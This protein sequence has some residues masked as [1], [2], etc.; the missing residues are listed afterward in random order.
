MKAFE[1]IISENPHSSIKLV[2]AGPLTDRFNPSKVSDYA[3]TLIEYS[4]RKLVDAGVPSH[5]VFSILNGV[6]KDLFK[7][8]N[9]DY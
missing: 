6:D 7:P 1:A 4:R 8:M 2:I 9:K 3:K 5:R